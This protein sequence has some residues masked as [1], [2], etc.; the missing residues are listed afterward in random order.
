MTTTK[1]S[2][3]ELVAMAILAVGGNAGFQIRT[4]SGGW[5]TVDGCR[6]PRRPL[7]HRKTAWRGA[8]AA[9]RKNKEE[10]I[11]STLW[12]ARAL[13]GGADEY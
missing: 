12:R 7:R 3:D 1:L 5:R 13:K 2:G 4:S 6:S 10:T 11:M 8:E 9:A